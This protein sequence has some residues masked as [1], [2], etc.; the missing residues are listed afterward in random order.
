M[1]RAAPAVTD[2]RI[3]CDKANGTAVPGQRGGFRKSV[4]YTAAFDR[5]TVRE[6]WGVCSRCGDVYYF[7]KATPGHKVR[8][9]RFAGGAA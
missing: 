8:Q 9:K 3:T 5:E 7:A 1:S 2:Y 6:G 4:S